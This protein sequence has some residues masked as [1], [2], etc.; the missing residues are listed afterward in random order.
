MKVGL[1]LLL[2][3]ILSPCGWAQ[4]ATTNHN[5]ILR[6]D[7]STSS[8]AIEH[9]QQGA[10]LFDHTSLLKYL[11]KLWNLGPLGRRTASPLVNSVEVAINL[12]QPPRDTVP[13]IRIPYTNLMPERPD[14]EKEDS[15]DHH[16]ALHAFAAFLSEKEDTAIAEA[17]RTAAQAAGIWSK[18]RANVGKSLLR[19]GNFLT[20]DLEKQNKE[21]VRLTTD[22]ALR[23]L[24][25]GGLN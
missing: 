15:S 11:T 19:L 12:E 23:R 18:A 6:R 16:K 20:K 7:P 10:R 5:V 25:R 13:F 24:R 3:L 9:M 8:P 1:A 4:E 14:L 22:V 21:K 2:V 17:I